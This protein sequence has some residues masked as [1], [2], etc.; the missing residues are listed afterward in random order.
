MAVYFWSNFR[1]NT[2]N[3]E[4]FPFWVSDISFISIFLG[5]A[6]F[7]GVFTFFFYFLTDFLFYFGF[8][9]MF[10]VVG[11]VIVTDDFLRHYFFTGNFVQN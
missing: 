11:T 1:L 7:S 5:F 9:D 6:V 2:G 3:R 4:N 8:I 10:C